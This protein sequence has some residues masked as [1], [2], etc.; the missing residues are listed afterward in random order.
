MSSTKAIL[1][2]GASGYIGTRLALKLRDEYKVYGTYYKHKINIPGVTLFPFN[3]ENRTW[4]KRIGYAL[5]PDIVIFVVGNNETAAAESNPRKAEAV[6]TGGTATAANVSDLLQAKFIYVST[7]YAFDGTR[8]NYHES[9]TVLP[10]TALGK[11]KLGGENYIRG[12]SLNYV[13]ARTSPLFGRGNGISISFLDRLRMSLDRGQRIEVIADEYHS[14]AP[15]EGFADLIHR[16]IDSGLKNKIVHYGGLTKVTQFEFAQA[17]AKRFKYD[18]ALVIPKR[19]MSR[20]GTGEEPV[21]DYSLNSTAT[22][23]ILKI[24]PLLLEESLDLVEKQLIPRF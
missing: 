2:I 5:R 21:R 22:S 7:C 12:K 13:I 14:I 17:F 15:L 18:P 19:R 24:K 23:E 11:A 8:G 3:A 10:T 1:I 16:L 9:D 20:R 4:A 6:Q